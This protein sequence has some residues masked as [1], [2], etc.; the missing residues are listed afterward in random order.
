MLVPHSRSDA[1]PENV[2]G[3]WDV[4]ISVGKCSN[5]FEPCKDA[6]TDEQCVPGRSWMFGRGLLCIPSGAECNGSFGLLTASQTGSSSHPFASVA[7]PPPAPRCPTA[8]AP[9]TPRTPRT[10]VGITLQFR[11]RGLPTF[12]TSGISGRFRFMPGISMHRCRFQKAYGSQSCHC[13][14]RWSL[15][16]P[17]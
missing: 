11:G 15:L 3:T 1:V 4:S 2:E 13:I 5:L 7:A 9:A 6:G 10:T 12:P 14:P 17:Q 16:P 8:T